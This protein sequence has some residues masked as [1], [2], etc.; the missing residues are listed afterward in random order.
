MLRRHRLRRGNHQDDSKK[1]EDRLAQAEEAV[2]EQTEK[3]DAEA[4]LREFLRRM[5]ER[6]HLAEAM[7]N[8]LAERHH[9]T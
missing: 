5:Y 9:R 2:Q 3:H 7:A 1:Y 8:A 6:N 4:P